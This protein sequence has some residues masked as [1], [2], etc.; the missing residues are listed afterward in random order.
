MR[1]DWV[2]FWFPQEN[3]SVN[4]LSWY[5]QHSSW[6]QI[7]STV[8]CR[9]Y[10]CRLYL[11]AAQS[12]GLLHLPLL[13]GSWLLMHGLS[14]HQFYLWR[15]HGS[16]GRFVLFHRFSRDC[17]GLLSGSFAVSCLILFSQ[18]LILASIQDHRCP[19][20]LIDPLINFLYASCVRVSI[21]YYK[22]RDICLFDSLRL[23]N[24]SPNVSVFFVNYDYLKKGE[25]TFSWLKWSFYVNGES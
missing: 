4:W 5:E 2:L 1:A 17:L 11:D 10:A 23:T 16:G 3:P 14:S 12:L 21:R 9:L 6:T 8:G 19:I 25:E 15:I 18:D 22:Y 20:Y 24:Q 13:W 7:R